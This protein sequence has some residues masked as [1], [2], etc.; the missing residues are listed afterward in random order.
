MSQDKLQTMIMPNF[1]G[2]KRCYMG[3]VQ[4]ENSLAL[5]PSPRIFKQQRNC[6]QSRTTC[7][8]TSKHSRQDLL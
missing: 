6:L 3:F 4:V 5:R 8:L 7:K 2:S 1:K